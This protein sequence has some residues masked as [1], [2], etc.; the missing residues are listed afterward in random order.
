MSRIKLK[1]GTTMP[2]VAQRLTL[3]MPG[4]SSNTLS[5][6]DGHPSDVTF[7]NESQGNTQY[8][9]GVGLPAGQEINRSPREFSLG[10]QFDSP[11]SSTITTPSGSEQQ[12]NTSMSA[13]GILDSI[14]NSALTIS[15]SQIP[16]NASLDVSSDVPRHSSS[17]SGT[18]RLVDILSPCKRCCSS[19]GAF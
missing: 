7:K 2:P 8:I 5:R 6:N 14:S 4:Q 15:T 10:G 1:V 12:Q 16:P 17:S 3:N 11:R 13:H 19:F 18:L 9:A